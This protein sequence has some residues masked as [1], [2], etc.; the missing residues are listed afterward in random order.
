MSDDHGHPA[1][2]AP[3][4][5]PIA[6]WFPLW[7]PAPQA[8]ARLLCIPCAG[9]GASVYRGWRD[10][11]PG[12]EILAAQLPGREHRIGESPLHDIEP[13]LDGLV[14]AIGLL[15]QPKA[16]PLPLAVFGHSLGGIVGFALCRRLAGAGGPTHLFVAACRA[17][18]MPPPRRLSHQDLPTIL[19]RLVA[20]GGLSPQA[21]TEPELMAIVEPMLRADLTLA[22]SSRANPEPPLSIPITV[23]GGI[24]D[25][26][27]GQ[28]ELDG[29]SR[30]TTAGC[31]VRRVPGGHFFV[32]DDPPAVAGIISN[33]WPPGPTAS[34]PR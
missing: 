9:R 34:T 25:G 18:H 30:L 15:P 7:R 28:E 1:R 26:L 11:L 16:G 22:E 23:L 20:M 8:R 13:I 33:R 31:D 19:D 4:P 12:V 32:L 21:R 27:V 5:R 24:D 10:L 29:W 6:T 14:T 17:A 2:R 3:T